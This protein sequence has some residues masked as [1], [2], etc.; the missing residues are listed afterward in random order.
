MVVYQSHEVLSYFLTPEGQQIAEQGSHEA[1]VWAALS[2]KGGTPVSI[3]D[4]KSKVG[5]ESAKV[6]QGRAFKSG[7]IVK[8]GENLY[9]AV[10][11]ILQSNGTRLLMDGLLIG[12]DD[13]GCH[14]R[15]HEGDRSNRHLEGGRKG[16]CRTQE[17]EIDCTKVCRDA[18]IPEPTL[19][20]DGQFAERAYGI[21]SVKAQNSA[22][23]LRSPRLI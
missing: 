7:W 12:T 14:T 5:D 19:I 6:G 13:P 22:L 21:P 2:E 23:R 15:R 16:T 17:E 11:D 20:L 3:K 1:R 18:G 8:D 10:S 9:K 4:L